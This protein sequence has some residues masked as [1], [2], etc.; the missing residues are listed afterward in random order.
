MHG[1]TQ[2]RVDTLEATVERL[3][4]E[5]AAITSEKAAL[6]GQVVMLTHVLRMRDEQLAQVKKDGPELSPSTAAVPSGGSASM[7]VCACASVQQTAV[8]SW[9]A[10]LSC[11]KISL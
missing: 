10:Q 6:Q 8:Q 3:Q 2:A 7:L 5:K 1:H 11:A 9:F 4:N